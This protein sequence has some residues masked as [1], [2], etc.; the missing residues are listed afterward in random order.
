MGSCPSARAVIFAAILSTHTTCTPNS[1]KQ[2]PV[3]NPT[4]PVPI[5]LM[6]IDTLP[7]QTDMQHAVLRRSWN[8]RLPLG[9]F[10]KVSDMLEIL[11]VQKTVYPPIRNCSIIG[12]YSKKL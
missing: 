4:Y 11:N 5:T 12:G 9:Y 8:R 10:W 2:A 7:Y 3:T 1:A 6:C